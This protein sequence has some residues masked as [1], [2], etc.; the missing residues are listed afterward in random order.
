MK[1]VQYEGRRT[2][3][4]MTPAKFITITNS[5]YIYMSVKFAEMHKIKP[6]YIKLFYCDDNP[7][8]IAL[9]FDEKEGVKLTKHKNGGYT[10]AITQFLNAINYQPSKTNLYK[11]IKKGNMFIIDLEKDKIE[12][13]I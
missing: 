6:G 4:S 8:I 1:F 3:S 7:K 10:G 12:T 2:R 9:S 5:K 13:G 11:F